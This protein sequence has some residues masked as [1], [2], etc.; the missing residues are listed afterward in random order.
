ADAAQ[1][2]AKL[3]LDDR[4]VAVKIAIVPGNAEESPLYQRVSSPDAKDMM[5]PP[6][7]KKPHL[8]DAQV[9]TI[10]AWIN[11]GAKYDQHWAY[12]KPLRP[13]VPKSAGTWPVTPID[14]F[15]ALEQAK[16][17]LTAAPEADRITLVRRLYFDLTGLP[18]TPADVDTFVNDKAP[19]AYEK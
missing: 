2:K 16:H 3:R 17:N 7:S 5:P 6:V 12:A 10:K 8:N 11:Q 4:A 15:I 14:Q 13:E 1:R 19:A 18:P 9:R